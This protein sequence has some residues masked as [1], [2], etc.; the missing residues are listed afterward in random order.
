M[1]CPEWD[2]QRLG[3]AGLAMALMLG[4]QIPGEEEPRVAFAA[5]AD[6]NLRCLVRPERLGEFLQVHRDMLL[7]CHDVGPFHEGLRV[8][9][10]RTGQTAAAG[11]LR[12]FRVNRLICDVGLLDQLVGLA[13]FNLE[14]RSRSLEV[15]A[16]EYCEIDLPDLSTLRSRPRL[17]AMTGQPWESVDEA[18]R[19]DALAI[20]QATLAIFG[21]VAGEAFQIEERAGDDLQAIRVG[22]PLS[23]A[24]QMQGA[25]VGHRLTRRGLLL[26]KDALDGL[27][28][29]CEARYRECSKLLYKDASA[30]RCFRWK[31][32]GPAPVV[33]LDQSGRP[34]V[35][36]TVLG[37][38]LEA[39][40]A[41][42][43]GPHGIPFRPPRSVANRI[44]TSPDHW[45]ELARIHPLLWAW[46]CLESAA[47]AIRCIGGLSVQGDRQLRPT[48]EVM[49][50]IRSKNPNIEMFRR[51]N[52]SARFEAPPGYSLLVIE[53]AD[54]ELR[55]L[56][57]TRHRTGKWSELAE[58]FRAGEDPISFTAAVL[59]S[60]EMYDP[61]DPRWKEALDAMR[62]LK[63]PRFDAW[64]RLARTFLRCAAHCLAPEHIREILRQELGEVLNILVPARRT[65]QDLVKPAEIRVLSGEISA[66]SPLQSVV[67]VGRAYSLLDPIFP[68]FF[69]LHD[70]QTL[71]LIW[72]AIGAD[73][74]E[75]PSFSLKNGSYRGELIVRLRDSLSGRCE[76]AELL[77]RLSELSTDPTWQER[78]AR[79]R[80][81]PDIYDE[82]F[83]QDVVTGAGR[84]RCG[85][86]FHQAA[87]AVYLDLADDV[88]KV[89]LDAIDVPGLKPVALS[90]DEIPLLVPEQTM[91]AAGAIEAATEEIRSLVEGAA[92]EFLQY[93]PIVCEVTSP[94]AW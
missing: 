48:Y 9:L 44:S 7:V 62:Q 93:V 86:E 40:L 55:C 11:V 76:H 8:H 38:W 74:M 26:R 92:R 89:V 56:A 65:R 17:D 34:S 3:G 54:L 52:P 18:S 72:D 49:P 19:E 27:P 85:L 39:K 71:S 88:R 47:D 66:S 31:A 21:A 75:M 67:N 32:G 37:R 33:A 79:G 57:E 10:R 94:V 61:A 15:L 46:S 23:Q 50:R 87:A 5:A 28:E 22:G 13:Q 81:S 36:E 41:S 83:L 12:T 4:Q 29:H 25:I 60:D 77:A 20:V 51:I 58:L 59:Y 53:L 14:R 24:I 64:M 82:I 63:S 78:L 70:D 6:G 42:T 16:S 80:G 45:G 2:G 35:N 73:P 91:K 84:I 1:D 69:D 43:P 90:G 30:R 68:E